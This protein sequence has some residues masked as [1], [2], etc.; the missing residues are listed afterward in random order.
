MVGLCV[1]VWPWLRVSVYLTQTEKL[2]TQTLGILDMF[3]SYLYMGTLVILIEGGLTCT[4]FDSST[5]TLLRTPSIECYGAF[6]FG[7]AGC[8]IVGIWA[9]SSIIIARP[10]FQVVTQ[11]ELVFGFDFLFFVGACQTCLAVASY[12]TSE[13]WARLGSSCVASI[14]FVYIFG[15]IK[16]CSIR[17]V[18]RIGM[19]AFI[20]STCVSMVRPTQVY[21][22]SSAPLFIVSITLQVSV[23]YKLTNDI[24]SASFGMLTVVATV[25]AFLFLQVVGIIFW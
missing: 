15:R 14:C 20:L 5:P 23:W 25:V 12:F 24:H 19:A 22:V 4:S 7:L 2:L 18:N 1:Q 16:P 8:A 13:S 9:F 11:A 17:Q 6:H 21:Q 10:L 3:A